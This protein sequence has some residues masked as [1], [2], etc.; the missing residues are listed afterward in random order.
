MTPEVYRYRTRS[1]RRSRLNIARV[2]PVRAGEEEFT[3]FVNGQKA[4]DIEERMARALRT[5]GREF[6]FQIEVPITG[7]FHAKLVDYL[8]FSGGLIYPIEVYGEIGHATSAQK[9]ADNDREAELNQTFRRNGRQHLQVDWWWELNTQEA[10]TRK[11]QRMF[12]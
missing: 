10:A 6:S 11:A 4:S 2:K 1:K 9:A 3:N 7:K 12:I 8:A 5:I